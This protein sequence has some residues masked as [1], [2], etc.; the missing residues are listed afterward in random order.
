MNK[1]Y[2]SD[3]EFESLPESEQVQTFNRILEDI[4]PD[5]LKKLR[6]VLPEI[7]RI[8]NLI[9]NTYKPRLFVRAQMFCDNTPIE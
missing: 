2:I 1:K 4:P 3:K 5:D 9:N 7:A 6:D 8:Q